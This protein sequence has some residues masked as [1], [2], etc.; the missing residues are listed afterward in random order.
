MTGTVPTDIVALLPRYVDEWDAEAVDSDD[1]CFLVHD[2]AWAAD[3]SGCC[4]DCGARFDPDDA[5]LG[6][7][8]QRL[9]EA[10]AWDA[11]LIKEAVS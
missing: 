3:L 10:A 11:G 5:A 8:A 9:V 6:E 2:V 4:R 7:E 1:V